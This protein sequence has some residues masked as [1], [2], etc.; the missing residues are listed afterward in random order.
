[1]GL[2]DWVKLALPSGS[3]RWNPR[4]SGDSFIA[5]GIA[6]AFASYSSQ[7]ITP[8]DAMRVPAVY[9]CVRMIVDRIVC[10]P[11]EV[12]TDGG[13]V[14]ETPWWLRPRPFQAHGWSD[15]CAQMIV[16]LLIDG[17]AYMG[18]APGDEIPGGGERSVPYVLSPN[19][20]RV[21]RTEGSADIGV[22]VDGVRDDTVAVIRYME[23]PEG[24]RG[25]SP[26]RAQRDRL[27]LGLAVQEQA[28]RFFSQGAMLPFALTSP[29]QLDVHQRAEIRREWLRS[30]AGRRNV[31]IPAVLPY[32][33]EPKILGASPEA[34]QFLETQRWVSAQIAETF[35][36]NSTEIGIRMSSGSDLTYRTVESRNRDLWER[37]LRPVCH[38][39]ESAMSQF[40]DEGEMR[41]NP[42]KF[43]RLDDSGQGEF[44]SRIAQ[45]SQ[46][47]G[48]TILGADEIRERLGYEPLPNGLGEPTELNSPEPPSPFGGGDESDEPP[49]G[50]EDEE[51]GSEEGGFPFSERRFE[52]ALREMSHA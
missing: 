2:S 29:G 11:V 23:A 19:R 15:W 39:I 9:T 28:A 51:N 43:L 42:D 33:L 27:G 20:V 30:A 47:F 7:R 45:A 10:M 21:E 52:A 13:R 46:T 41:F 3:N 36:I 31:H 26:L 5:S 40:L 38:R 18:F 24:V 25:I 48:V 34:A 32:G 6:E 49:F 17:N 37:A 4:W 16:S 50:G 44:I 22:Y 8:T 1:M 35:G 14:L 12:S